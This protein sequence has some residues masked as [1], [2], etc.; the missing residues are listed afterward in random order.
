MKLVC[1]RIGDHKGAHEQ[2]AFLLKNI[3]DDE[4]SCDESSMEETVRVEWQNGT[5]EEIPKSLIHYLVDE[6]SN[7]L[8]SRYYRR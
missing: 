1:A 6:G 4:I 3:S 8:G 2:L 5:T 7:E